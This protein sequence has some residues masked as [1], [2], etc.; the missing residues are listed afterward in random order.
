MENLKKEFLD[1]LNDIQK[2]III[3]A[4]SLKNEARDDEATTEKIKLNIVGIFEKMFLVSYR[5]AMQ[6]NDGDAAKL[7]VLKDNYMGHFNKI[8]MSWYQ[9]LEKAKEH[10]DFETIYIEEAK[11]ATMQKI[12]ALF[13]EMVSD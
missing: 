9:R 12:K 13:E 4:E 3:K 10:E 7:Q 5:K 11:I 6:C 8:P 2:E 1:R